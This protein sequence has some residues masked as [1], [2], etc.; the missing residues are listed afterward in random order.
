MGGCAEECTAENDSNSAEA[1]FIDESNG[2]AAFVRR[3][4]MM[5]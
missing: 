3:G 2:A 4:G 5:I 1:A